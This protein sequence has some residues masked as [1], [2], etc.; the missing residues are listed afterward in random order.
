MDLCFDAFD[1][2]IY[3][4]S[5]LIVWRNQKYKIYYCLADIYIYIYTKC[6]K[7][8]STDKAGAII[9][10]TVTD[11]ICATKEQPAI[12]GSLSIST[13]SI[14][15]MYIYT[16]ERSPPTFKQEASF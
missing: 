13:H 3:M 16:A 10:L 7:W 11:R 2:I 12:E 15:Q 14:K 5:V 9:L 1:L 4:Q 8:H 6:N